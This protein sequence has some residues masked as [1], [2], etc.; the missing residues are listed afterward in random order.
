MDTDHIIEVSHL[1]KAYRLYNSKSDRL[2]EAV[3][4]RGKKYHRL[5]YALSDIS[6]SVRRGEILGILGVNGSGKSTLLKIL[7]GVVSATEGTM[8]VRGRVSALL[9]LGAGFNPEY[10]GL[11]NID[12]H[13]TMM[14]YSPEEMQSRR[15]EIIRFADIGD[16]IGQPVKNYSSGMF[17]RLA[18][19]VAINVNPEILIV[20]E[21]LS[22]GDMRFQIKCMDRMK[23]MMENGTTILYVSHDISSVR[24]FCQRSMWLHQ[25]Q[26]Q[27]IGDT[28]QIA[29]MYADFLKCNDL[30]S[31]ERV[32][33]T[34]EQ[35]EREDEEA[36]VLPASGDAI[37]SIVRFEL[38]NRLGEPVSTPAYDEP[39]T[40]TVTY[41]VY[42][43]S[44][45]RPVLGVALFSIDD[46]Y[47]CGLNTLLDDEKIPW[48]YGRNRFSLYYPNGLRAMG[49]KYYFD[50]TLRDK[51]AT[52]NIDYRKCIKEISI[53][54][55][56]V[57]EGRLVLP[58]VW[59]R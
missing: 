50:A 4:F 44:I 7:S 9:E 40:V 10:T 47:I 25:G 24:R 26:L 52:V 55:G 56:Y 23:E 19:A 33:E 38:K 6:F 48:K 14:G 20:D 22:V 30:Q 41:D 43:E 27:A 8:A 31:V 18:F 36:F 46:E 37:A 21:T 12:L 17:A 28:D 5:F 13:G 39:V 45:D 32:R 59:G 51:T 2:R 58:H 54:S 29:D 3:S 57:A 49:G 42:D 1:S 16:F 34:A 15:E 11:E 35:Q 53:T